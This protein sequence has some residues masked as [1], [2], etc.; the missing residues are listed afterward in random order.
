MCQ[1]LWMSA[2][3]AIFRLLRGIKTL[4]YHFYLVEEVL[5]F[6]LVGHM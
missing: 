5:N 1:K 3:F 4:Q 2:F 6:D